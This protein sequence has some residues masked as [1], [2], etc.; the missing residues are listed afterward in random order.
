MGSSAMRI[1]ALP[2]YSAPSPAM[3]GPAVLMEF[4]I[5]LAFERKKPG[6]L[7]MGLYLFG[8]KLVFSHCR[9]RLP[10]CRVG[11]PQLRVPSRLLEAIRKTRLLATLEMPCVLVSPSPTDPSAFL[12]RFWRCY[13][14][15]ELPGRA[16]YQ[17]S[18][19]KC[20]AGHEVKSRL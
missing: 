14:V 20:L 9:C 4:V 16:R 2:A 12:H 3:A 5:K 15:L 18:L 10:T 11:R 13:N 1:C 17:D 8:E 19:R 6:T 7:N